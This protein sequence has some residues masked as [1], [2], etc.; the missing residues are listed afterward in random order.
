MEAVSGKAWALIVITGRRQYRGNTGYEDDL[1]EAYRYDSDVANSRQLSEGDVVLLRDQNRMLGA[2]RVERVTSR[3][4]PKQRLRCPMCR[5]TAIKERRTK[6]PRWRCNNRHEF[7]DPSRETVTVTHYEAHFGGTFQ[8]AQPDIQTSEIKKAALRPND[9]LSIEQLDPDRLA[10][11][12]GSQVPYLAALFAG[13]AHTRSLMPDDADEGDD[14]AAAGDQP[15]DAKRRDNLLT[16]IRARRGQRTFRNR[17]IRRYGPRCM[18]SGCPLIDI[19][20]AAHIWPYRTISD[21]NPDNGL[22]LRADLHTLFDLDLMGIHPETHEVRMSPDARK[23]G[24]EAFNGSKVDVDVRAARGPSREALAER[25]EAF[26][27]ASSEVS[28]Q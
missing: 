6:A 4:G 1:A 13:L 5:I 7:E 27:R 8:S 22:L 17:L 24:Y 12:I 14:E 10:L 18:V 16:T 19:V 3:Q 20:E 21:S 25:W 26:L 11:A 9:Q 23:A 2:A 28:S 15:S